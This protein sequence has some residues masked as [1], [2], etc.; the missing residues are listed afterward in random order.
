M[1]R[2]SLIRLSALAMA[3]LAYALADPAALTP[4]QLAQHL[5]DRWPVNRPLPVTT[6]DE[7]YAFQDAVVAILAQHEGEPVG[8]KAALT[9]AALQ[10]RF[11]YDRP[12]LGV[13]LRNMLLRDRVML[14]EGF[15]ASPVLEADLMAVV[16]DEALN[17]ATTIEDV[18]A[19]LESL[20]P[21]VEIADLVF[22]EGTAVEPLWLTAI[23]AGARCGVV[24][25]PLLARDAPDAPSRLRDVQATVMDRQ[26]QVLASGK[27]DRL[28]G[29]PLEVVLWIR[30]EV[31]ARGRSLKR[32][33]VL[34]LGSLT[35]L[36]PAQ[37]GESYQVLF[38]GLREYPVSLQV[39]IRKRV[40][41]AP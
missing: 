21:I 2:R 14:D 38:T 1:I 41:P 10:Q 28:L 4:A 23:N 40:A 12:V 19:A 8:Y 37:A 16:G 31:K 3:G 11:H 13:L 15:A 9:S 30:D 34:W 7:A 17:D 36:V 24:G 26:G 22:M 39:N 27:A 18:W 6:L 32:G 35:D 20:H 29:H 25:D 33:D 5:A